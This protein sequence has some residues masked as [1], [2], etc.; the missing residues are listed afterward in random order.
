VLANSPENMVRWLMWPTRVS[1]LTAMP[2]LGVTEEDARNMAA[3]LAT[4]KA[5]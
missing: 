2:D 1:P 5:R 3:Y 4:L